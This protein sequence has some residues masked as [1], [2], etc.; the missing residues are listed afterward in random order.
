MAEGRPQPTQIGTYRVVRPLGIGVIGQTYL[1]TAEE[2]KAPVV[3]KILEGKMARRQPWASSL[4]GEALH[5]HL[6]RYFEVS[7]EGQAGEYLV[8]DYLNARPLS[9]E[10]MARF[11]SSETVQ[12][13]LR[14][15]EAVQAVHDGGWAVGNLKPSNVLIREEAGRAYPVVSDVGILYRIQPSQLQ[16][17]RAHRILP[18]LAPEL[19]EGMNASEDGFEPT[20]AADVYAFGVLAA[21][22]LGRFAPYL[23]HVPPS[24]EKILAAKRQPPPRY[25]LVGVTGPSLPLIVDRVTEFVRRCTRPDPKERFPSFPPMLQEFAQVVESSPEEEEPVAVGS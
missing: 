19:V 6:V 25:R 1:A 24:S 2:D 12:A 8:S 11:D 22:A 7:S 16:G 23:L 21:E 13:L 18:Y 9:F 15:G 5:P 14:V 10:S 20:V 4:E 17:P 3:I